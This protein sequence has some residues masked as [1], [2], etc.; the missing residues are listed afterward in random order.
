MIPRLWLESLGQADVTEME[1]Q[2]WGDWFGGTVK[3]EIPFW[4]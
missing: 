1:R 3:P 2:H 4:T